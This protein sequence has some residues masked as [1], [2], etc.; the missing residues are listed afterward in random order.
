[1]TRLS[2][3]NARLDILLQGINTGQLSDV[4]RDT[5]IRQA[6]WEYSVDL[7]KSETLEIAGNATSYYLLFGK[8]VDVDE[9]GR[10]AEIDLASSGAGLKLGI[11][12]TLDY[13]MEIT[14]INLWLARVGASVAGTVT[15]SLYTDAAGLPSTLIV[16]SNTIDIDGVEGAPQGRYAGVEFP[17]GATYELPAGTYHAV[18]ASSGYTYA[19]G[20]NEVNLG[21]DQSTVTNDV[22]TYD[23]STWTA[24]ATASQGIL[25]VIGNVRGW[26]S[27]NAG[28]SLGSVEYPAADVSANETPQLLG[29]EAH[30]LFHTVRG[31]WLR[32][33]GYAPGS[34]ESLRISYSHPYRWVEGSDPTI[35]TPANHTDAITNL[36][37]SY[38]CIWLAARYGQNR[39]SSISADSVERRTQLDQYRSLSGDFRKRYLYLSGQGGDEI[40]AGQGSAEFTSTKRWMFH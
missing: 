22:N 9:A 19:S 29:S 35:D 3:F 4:D 33:I 31:A 25:E 18:L 30:G 40:G 17:L 20:T 38:A 7:P 39:D 11:K 28:G 13:P 21:V 37:A 5:A 26:S 34:S 14:Q 10:D 1:M 24:Y 16:A 6:M 32:L 15:A 36:A 12:F 2:E 23:G 27:E 8:V